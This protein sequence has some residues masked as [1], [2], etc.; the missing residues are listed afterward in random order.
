MRF[1]VFLNQYYT[2]D[3][4][5]EATNLYEQVDLMECLGFDGAAVGERHVHEEGFIEPITALSALAARTE[6][7]DLATMAMLPMIYDPLHL[8]EQVAMIDQFSGGRMRF[9]AA[10]GYRE[11]EIETFGIDMDDRSTAF[12]ESLHVLDRLWNED[13][14]S[15][16]GEYWSFDD[17]FVSPKPTREL[18]V[19]IGGHADIAIKRAAYRGDGWIASA[20]STTEDLRHQIGVYED[21]LAEFDEDR[22]DHEIVLMRDCFVADSVEDARETI[23]PYLLRLYEWY[24]RWGQTYM[25]E[26]E[27][28]VDYEELAEKF[29]LGSPAACIEQLREYERLGVDQVYLRCQFPGQPQDTTLETIE[30]LGT[31]VIPAFS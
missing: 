10:I 12:I 31:E 24:A 9:G 7:I 6:T 27:I 13:R 23:E 22:D 3:G 20:S 29:V 18:P 19:W 25:D 15:H 30:R 4:D 26:H 2:E 17:V 5:F 28:T 16:D 21:A 11:R 8:A 14:V 1:G